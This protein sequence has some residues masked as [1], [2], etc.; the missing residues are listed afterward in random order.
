MQERLLH[1]RDGS[2]TY[3]V[4]LEKGDDVLACLTEFARRNGVSAAQFSGLGGLGGATVA[5]F[6]RERHEYLKIPV[7]GQVEV[8]SLVGNITL[9]EGRPLVHAH[10][11]LGGPDGATRGGHLLE[12]RVW[13]TLEVIVV[14]L[15]AVLARTPDPESGLALL[16]L[17][18]PQG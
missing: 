14:S 18:T 13:P 3:V 12:G 6:D 8:V 7:D 4:V 2:K 11:V 5:Y 10:A 17:E 16:D 15:P 9:A 1:E